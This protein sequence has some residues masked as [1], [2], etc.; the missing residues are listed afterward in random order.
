MLKNFLITEANAIVENLDLIRSHWI[1]DEMALICLLKTCQTYDLYFES[2]I[3]FISPPKFLEL[4]QIEIAN[5]IYKYESA[6]SNTKTKRGIE[7]QRTVPTSASQNMLQPDA[8]KSFFNNID[9]K[10]NLINL[11]MAYLRSNIFSNQI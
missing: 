7:Q 9:N 11:L 6:K 4:I 1:V 5:D 3:Q 8:L 10:T 2:F